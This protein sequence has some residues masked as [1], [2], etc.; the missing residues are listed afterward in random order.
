[1]DYRV[2]VR[3]YRHGLGDCFLLTFKNE[4]DEP[5]HMLIDCGA[6][7][8]D[9][10]HM[11]ALVER[12]RD[13]VK[14]DGAK[15]RL[16]VVVGTHEHKDHISGFNQARDTFSDDFDFGSVWL[17]WTENLTQ[18]QIR[19]VKETKKKALSKLRDILKSPQA[20]AA[21]ERF[22]R[23]NALLQFSSEDDETET[24]LVSDAIRYLKQRGKDC[25]DLRYLEP[26]NTF[27]LKDVK[28]VNVYVLGPPKDAS[29]MKISA[30]TEE[31]KR[32]NI[33]YHLSRTGEVGIDA[34]SAAFDDTSDAMN[35]RFFPFA[36]EHRIAWKP[37]VSAARNSLY[38]PDIQDFVAETYLD[39]NQ[40]WRRIDDDWLFA[41]DQLALD[42]DNDTNNTSLVLAFELDTGE[43][44][45]FPADAQVGNWLSWGTVEFQAKDGRK[46][47]KAL[48]LLGRTAFYKVGHHCS[49]N[50][51]LKN[52]GLELMTRD[53]LVAFIPLDIATAK[54]QGT[55]GWAMPAPPL[56]AELKK[57]AGN[58]VVISDVDQELS[59]EAQEAGVVE[60]EDY[61]D[62]FIR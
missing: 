21:P 58:R 62:Y 32:D 52:G 60:T 44:L 10:T 56:H 48:E 7:A 34:I 25:G 38:F 51:T 31:M 33:I 45:L 17:A 29:F 1:M 57:K 24:K 6:L 43:V 5:F 54:K 22:E 9:K 46:P 28:G 53:D 35:E 2:R 37:E 11:T 3:M 8:R 14:R 39:L 15:A 16:D 23:V 26:G 4:H 50:A 27:P 49:H 36:E 12:I 61:I 42:L 30:V 13:D 40:R 18:P 47:M 41:I 20:T 59:A 55:K 19:K